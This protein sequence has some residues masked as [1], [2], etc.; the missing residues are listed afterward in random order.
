MPEESVQKKKKFQLI[1]LH[2]S[3]QSHQYMSMKKLKIYLFSVKYKMCKIKLLKSKD[4][5]K[6]RYRKENSVL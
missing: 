5:I 6:I 1:L 3:K 4:T 2:S